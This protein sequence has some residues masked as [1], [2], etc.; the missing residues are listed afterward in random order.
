MT[1]RQ[2]IGQGAQRLR[3]GNTA[4]ETA[5]RDL[6]QREA[7]WLLSRLT[8]C[9]VA[10]LYLGGAPINA[11]IR[12]AFLSRIMQRAEGAPLQYLLGDAGF[13]GLTLAV[14]PGVFIPRPET[15]TVV[16]AALEAFGRLAEQRR[17]PL[18]L[19]D[20]G[21]GSGC[22]AVALARALPACHVVAV[23]LS[24]DAVRIACANVRRH[25]L[26]E[27]VHVVQG[28][29]AEPLR[30]AFDGIVSNPPYIPSDEIDRLPFDVRREPRVS[31]DGGP[32]GL[33]DLR[34]V[35]A[36][37]RDRLATGGVLA[38]ECGEEHVD[39]LQREIRAA[40]WAAEITP[41]KDLAGCARGLLAVRASE[42][43]G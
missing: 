40:G 34:A 15:E 16:E 32:D 13:R 14:A 10:D 28:R 11:Q 30:G 33:R 19:L 22:I 5:W 3:R 29:W 39:P 35:A 36:Q 27:R 43:H 37:S 31:L 23:E 21:T 9:A 38:L 26:A 41:L 42:A 6:A 4:D 2:L 8:G 7:E 20:L 17:S 25:G 18:Q 1:A 12:E 24:W